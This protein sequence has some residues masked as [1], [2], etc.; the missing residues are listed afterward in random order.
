MDLNITVS[1]FTA[2]LQAYGI[3][4]YLSGRSQIITVNGEKSKTSHVISGIPQ[5]TVLG[6]CYLLYIYK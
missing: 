1:E 4:A 3:K 2:K 6:P 5:G